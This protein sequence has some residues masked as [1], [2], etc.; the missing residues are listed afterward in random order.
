MTAVE[1]LRRWRT[2]REDV[3]ACDG[4]GETAYSHGCAQGSNG[5]GS[6]YSGKRPR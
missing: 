5:R 2:R 6:G 4:K 3:P 1:L